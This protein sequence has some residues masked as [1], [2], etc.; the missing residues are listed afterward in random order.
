MLLLHTLQVL[1]ARQ[2]GTPVQGMPPLGHRRRKKKQLSPPSTVSHDDSLRAGQRGLT[3]A[4]RQTANGGNRADVPVL[5]ASMSHKWLDDAI[6]EWH[7]SQGQHMRIEG[8]T[9]YSPQQVEE[10]KLVL[11]LLPVFLSSILYWCE[12]IIMSPDAC[13]GP[14]S[15]SPP[16]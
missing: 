9:G 2:P 11:R 15:L 8:L 13:G 4:G 10:V 14:R 5:T 16:R 3:A 12:R 7:T 6:T 1:I